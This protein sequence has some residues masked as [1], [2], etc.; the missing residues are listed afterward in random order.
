MWTFLLFNILWWLAKHI[1]GGVIWDK[2][3]RC[4]LTLSRI[5]NHYLVYKT[6]LHLFYCF[7]LDPLLFNI[8]FGPKI[9]LIS[10]VLCVKTG[11]LKFNFSTPFVNMS[12]SLSKLS[13]QLLSFRW[14][15]D[16]LF[17]LKVWKLFSSLLSLL[18][19][20]SSLLLILTNNLTIVLACACWILLLSWLNSL[21]RLYNKLSDCKS[22]IIYINFCVCHIYQK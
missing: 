18:S 17:F 22:R 12:S 13:K 16:S 6:C 9:S 14:D 4:I 15:T 20:S 21:R 1:F 10:T 3:L 19:K 7:L 8:T 5:T 11:P 2:I